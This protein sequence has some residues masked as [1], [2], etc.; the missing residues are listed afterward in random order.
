MNPVVNALR[1]GVRR[2][3]RELHQM[4]TNGQ[5]LASNLVWIVGLL[6]PLIMLR[7]NELGETGLSVASFVLP[8]LMS[9]CVAFNGMFSLAQQLVVERQD[10]T[11]L[12]LKA[13]P[14]G[15]LGYLIGKILT[16]S[17]TVLVAC[18]VVTLAGAAM[19]EDVTGAD[20]GLG[21]ALAWVLPLGL[22]AMLP[23]GAVLGA[24]VKIGRAARVAS[25]ARV[26]DDLV[27]PENRVFVG[28]QDL[29]GAA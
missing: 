2:G 8:S 7:D 23:I 24:R 1:E 5:D 29:V 6:A 25:R 11:L 20:P 17:C 14:H 19:L 21:A 15:M 26:A 28:R 3:L 4:V 9:M 12:R 16:V 22:L 10:G 27:V 13:L 18:L